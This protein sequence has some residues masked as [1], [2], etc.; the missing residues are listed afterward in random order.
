MGWYVE[1]YERA[2]VSINLTDYHVTSLHQVFEQCSEQA[3]LL[4]LRV[5]GSE[6]VGMV[7]LEPMLLAGRHYLAK[8]GRSR[9]VSEKELLTV[10]VQSLG[11]QDL[12][13]FD[14]QQKII[15]YRVRP[16]EK[17]L[18]QE[19]ISDFLDQLASESVAP[20][21]GSV[22][23]LAGAL[24]ASLSSMVANLTFEKKGF[25]SLK[26][27]MENIA[28]R[29][30]QLKSRFALAVDADVLA[31]NK[32][33]EARRLPK[34]SPEQVA[35]GRAALFVANK[36]AI[37]VPLSVVDMCGEA[38]DLASL[39]IS[40][41]NPN[42]LSDAGCAVLNAVSAAEGAYMNVLI[43]LAALEKDGEEGALRQKVITAATKQIKSLREKA[44]SLNASVLQ[45]LEKGLLLE[46]A[47]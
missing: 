33:V 35:A 24:S 38:L 12:A 9:G 10:A 45:E 39:V 20:G 46:T 44:S 1:E 16:K 14:C 5:T 23:A 21:G 32:V 6:I 15:E 18:R 11:L 17:L 27:S 28:I 25:E 19:T 8:Q 29:A 26:E 22:S 2:Q 47:T 7:P 4:G 41:G 13:P 40:D 31:F 36:E 3:E 34:D 42:S 37:D 30:Q 43:N